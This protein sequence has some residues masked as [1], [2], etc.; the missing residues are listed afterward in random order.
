MKRALLSI[1]FSIL[2]I[3]V[4]GQWNTIG[5]IDQKCMHVPQGREES[6]LAHIYDWQNEH[7]NDYDV[8]FYW[9]DI[10][11]SETSTYVA[12]NTTMNAESVIVLDTFAFELINDP[13]MYIDSIFFNGVKYLSYTRD[14]DD[15]LVPVAS[16][17][18]GSMFTAQ[19]YYHGDPGSVG[20]L[21]GLSNA[22]N[23]KYDKHVTWSLSEPFGAKS[24]F[25]VKQDLED[26]ADSC[27]VFLT[28]DSTNMAGSE[29]LLTNVVDLGNGKT[30]YE[31]KC[32]Y[33]IDY[34]LI[35]F[36][37]ADY[38]D[39][40]IYAHPSQMNGDSLL[41]QNFIY[42]TPG[43]LADNKEV[44]DE[45]PDMIELY[46]NLYTLY[47]FHEEKYG[48]CLTELGGGMEHQTMTTIGG[49]WWGVVAHEMGHM[50]F[51]DN[52]TCAT[53]SDIWINE[54]F[55]TYSNYLCEEY[56]H[57]WE[58]GKQ[59]ISGAQNSVMSQPGG[60]TYIPENQI[61]EPNQWR[62]FDGRLSYNKG[63]AII[64]TLR[65][66]IQDDTMF[67]NV[68]KTFQN[69]FS[70]STATGEDFKN[71]AED[72][73]GM[74]FEQ[75]FDQWYYGQGYPTYDIEYYMLDD[76][77]HMTVTQTTSDPST[78]LFVM[79]MDYKLYFSDGSDTS[80]K[81]TQTDNLNE[82]SVYTGKPVTNIVVDP[83]DWT[84]EKV[85]SISVTVNESDS[86]DYFTIGPNPVKNNLNIYFLYP[87]EKAREIF[88]SDLSGKIILKQQSSEKQISINTSGFAHG[89]Y[90]V[91]VN[92]NTSDL[93]RKFIK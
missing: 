81:L 54:G 11:V 33:P 18:S 79:L 74:D 65:H 61:S 32:S 9:L 62:I 70:D 43:C 23:E 26:K 34:Y 37:V 87:K 93:I 68:M 72:V 27:W 13:D 17:D 15:V 3:S 89:V 83:E 19:V 31:W 51:G 53:W 36:A 64:H 2:I 71:V 77:L 39:Y 12:G 69:E 38:Q 67:F 6:V 55:A 85:G 24:W 25:A 86:P 52:V 30:R 91:Q 84:M 58:S 49:F 80:V 60:S 50:W 75:F 21:S 40:S 22:Y 28:T 35:S 78:P 8:K 7:L 1:I 76:S 63:A 48:H 16:I 41:I 29:G 14:G 44:I 45:T 57:G 90:F 92:D 82:F 5:N 20:F 42:D 73:T 4:Y 66:E 46:S 56:L 47:P 88:V 59:F 10:E